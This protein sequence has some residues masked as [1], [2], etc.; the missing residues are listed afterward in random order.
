MFKVSYFDAQGWAATD[1]N[2]GRFSEAKI[3]AEEAVEART[4]VRAEVRDGAGRLMYRRPR[5]V[6]P[7]P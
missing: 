1:E 7:A 5:T 3:L 2:V 4:A 6:T